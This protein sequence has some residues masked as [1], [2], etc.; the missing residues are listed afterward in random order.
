MLRCDPNAFCTGGATGLFGLVR[1]GGSIDPSL[2]SAYSSIANSE[3]FAAA[4]SRY[5]AFA[6]KLGLPETASVDEINVALANNTTFASTPNVNAGLFQTETGFY[7]QGNP[8]GFYGTRAG[9]HE[10][11]HLGAALKGQGDTLVHEIGVQLSTTP[12][13]LIGGGAVI[14]G[15]TAG[16]YYWA[17]H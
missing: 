8:L 12:E 2:G 1:P 14:A 15:G 4:L 10:L 13:I 9:S 7:L 3:E 6:R 5:N 17:T 16:G 11:V